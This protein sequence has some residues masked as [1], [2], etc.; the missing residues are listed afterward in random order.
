MTVFGL[1]HSYVMNVTN[2]NQS[3]VKSEISRPDNASWIRRE[4]L[5]L[6]QVSPVEK[7]QYFQSSDYLPGWMTTFINVSSNKFI[8]FSRLWEMLLIKSVKFILNHSVLHRMMSVHSKHKT[9]MKHIFDGYERIQ[10]NGIHPSYT[11]HVTA[12]LWNPMILISMVLS[13]PAFELL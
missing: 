4:T 10:K 2:R 11:V 9:G 8:I 7:F 5:P 1:Y 13:S 6:N 3:L 12:P